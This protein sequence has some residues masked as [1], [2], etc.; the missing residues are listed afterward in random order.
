METRL[1]SVKVSDWFLW[2][3]V[4]RALQRVCFFCF[5]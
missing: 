4:D 5:Y 1:T 3:V 2:W